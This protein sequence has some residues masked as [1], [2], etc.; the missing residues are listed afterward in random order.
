MHP[1]EIDIAIALVSVI[2]TAVYFNRTSLL[3][4]AK[5]GEAAALAKVKAEVAAVE[6]KAKAEVAA[7]AA[8][9]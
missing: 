5:S 9:L 1:I 3:A 7:V 6:S 8:K 2:A 4:R